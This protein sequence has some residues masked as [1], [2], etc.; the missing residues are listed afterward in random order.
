MWRIIIVALV[1][2]FPVLVC[3]SPSWQKRYTVDFRLGDSDSRLDARHAALED[4]RRLAVA[5]AETYVHTSSQYADGEIQEHIEVVSAP[6][7]LLENIQESLTLS[8]TGQPVL[9]LSADATLDNR[10][11]NRR[12]DSLLEREARYER[13]ERLEVENQRLRERVA[14]S[15]SYPGDT[16]TLYDQLSSYSSEEFVDSASTRSDIEVE[17]FETSVNDSEFAEF[18]SNQVIPRVAD[19]GVSLTPE[20]ARERQGGW[21]IGFYLDWHLPL[22]A[23]ESRLGDRIRLTPANAYTW[24]GEGNNRGRKIDLLQHRRKHP[25]SIHM[26]DQLARWRG[27]VI[28]VMVDQE[29]EEQPVYREPFWY[30]SR[31]RGHVCHGDDAEPASMARDARYL[32][33]LEGMDRAAP[34][35]ATP[36]IHARISLSEAE[37]DALSHL[38]A[39]IEWRHDGG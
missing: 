1:M 24:P 18:L 22:E 7:V 3:A 9:Q 23:L 14:T 31:Y 13:A 35:D 32:C 21:Q 2:L 28:V 38:E 36:G 33:L 37:R 4:I 15:P 8:D 26:I 12:I 27:D 10:L 34:S 29:G 5:E 16:V 11:L 30:V 6:M 17:V 25:E 20:S 19:K 39:K